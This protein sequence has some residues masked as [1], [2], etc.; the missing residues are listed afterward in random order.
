MVRCRKVMPFRAVPKQCYGSIL[1]RLRTQNTS[2]RFRFPKIA[3]RYPQTPPDTSQTPQD[4][5]QIPPRHCHKSNDTNRCQLKLPDILKQRPSVSLGVLGWLFVSV[6]VCCHLLF[7]G[8]VWGVSG[9]CLGGVQGISEWY[10]QK[11]EVLGC[12]WW[13]SGFLLGFQPLQYAAVTL[14]SHSLERHDFFHLTIVRP[15]NI[16]MSIYEVDKND[17]VI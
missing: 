2:K 5:P 13:V 4:V 8:H 10:S 3:L 12:V 15:Q 7:P 9:G 14:F 1:Q 6:G 11:S 16:K 17:W